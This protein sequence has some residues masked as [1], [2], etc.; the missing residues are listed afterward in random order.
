M[1]DSILT[2]IYEFLVSHF[3]WLCDTIG[4]AIICALYNMIDSPIAAINHF[5]LLLIDMFLPY[6]PVTP[7]EYQ[8][9]I[10]LQSF[11]SQFPQ[12]GFGPIYEIFKGIS[13]MLV[14]YGVFIVYKLLPF[15]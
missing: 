15:T 5:I 7:T 2:S 13:G 8:L 10:L 6:L 4:I 12:I 1:T 14:I 9:S 3:S 11:A